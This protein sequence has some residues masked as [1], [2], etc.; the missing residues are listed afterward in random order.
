MGVVLDGGEMAS[1]AIDMAAVEKSSDDVLGLEIKRVRSSGL[2]EVG[3]TLSHAFRGN[4]VRRGDVLV[5]DE[6]DDRRRASTRS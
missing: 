6:S 2:A 3:I 4:S 1:I 5:S